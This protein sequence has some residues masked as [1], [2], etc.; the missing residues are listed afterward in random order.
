MSYLDSR[1][2]KLF[3]SA[4]RGNT[5]TIEYDP[6]AKLT[7]EYNLTTII[8]RIVDKDSFVISRKI[9]D[10]KKDILKCS[11]HGYYFSIDLTDESS[12]NGTNPLAKFK[13]AI[14]IYATIKLQNVEG[15]YTPG[16]SATKYSLLSLTNQKSSTL[17]ILDDDEDGFVGLNLSDTKSN[18]I[19][20]YSLLILYR[21][22]ITM[23]WSIPE[24]SKLKISTDS[25][26]N[27]IKDKSKLSD[28]FELDGIT[29]KNSTNSVQQPSLIEDV[30]LPLLISPSAENVS[31]CTTSAMNSNLTFNPLTNI[32]KTNRLILN[33]S[34]T[35][36]ALSVTGKSIFNGGV[37]INSNVNISG[38]LGVQTINTSEQIYCNSL[39]SE[40]DIYI[41]KGNVE[42]TS[43]YFEGAGTGLKG[44]ATNLTVG[45]ANI[46]TTTRN[47]KVSDGTNI[48]DAVSVNGSSDINIKLPQNINVSNL[49]ANKVVAANQYKF[50]SE[51]SNINS[52]NYIAGSLSSSASFIT[53]GAKMVE[54]LPTSSGDAISL[55]LGES[56]NGNNITFKTNGGDY[57]LVYNQG[58]KLT[59]PTYTYNFGRDG[60]FDVNTIYGSYAELTN[61]K[62]TSSINTAKL[63]ATTS[64]TSPNFVG[65]STSS[66]ISDYIRVYDNNG[67]TVGYYKL[68]LNG[69]TMTFQYVGE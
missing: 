24:E 5:E 34:V 1:R 59:T 40:S 15:T 43:G 19:G 66:G 8:N 3:P 58:F 25:I 18:L 22:N 53:L 67:L 39:N 49:K 7:T 64:I 69:T 9:E 16:T 4:Y 50:C 37:Q 27:P 68:I 31:K 52:T 47:F 28:I 51:A 63:T 42:I 29:I 12:T 26:Y 65:K 30:E 13:N 35:E 55:S 23:S 48:G 11:I 10:D 33:T 21:D 20:T 61:L 2:V 14:Q 6:E 45:K 17:N 54:I 62:T 32:L 38:V 46:W 57:K 56:V 41:T 36:N 60:R 44:T